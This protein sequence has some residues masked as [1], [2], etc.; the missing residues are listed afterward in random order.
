MEIDK[1]NNG[2]AF[3]DK[4]HKYWD[5][6]DPKKKFISVTTLIEKFGQ[7]FNK[8]FWSAYKALERLIPAENWKVEKKSLLNTQKFDKSILDLYDISEDEFNKTQ[9]DILDEWQKTNQE[10]CERGTKIHSELE[11]SF[12]KMGA[13]C[14]LKKFGIGG[15]F[16]CKKNYN[17]LD[18]ENGV[19]PEYLISRVSKDG[20]LCLAGQIDVLVK[21]GNHIT[22]IDHKTNS[23]IDTKGFFNSKTKTTTKMKYPLNNL[24]DCSYS[25]YNLQLSTYAWMVQMMCPGTEVDDLILNHYDHDGN[26]TIYHMPYLKTEVIKMLSYYKKQRIHELQ[27]QKYKEIEY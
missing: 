8:D 15:K 2:I 1:E 23:K 11:N 18:L 12:Y 21:H 26:N 20:I 25:H 13:N 22:I 5:V 19:Y 7:P 9:Q 27:E 14:T 17:K 16:V 6:N 10:A 4:A 24:D 3:N